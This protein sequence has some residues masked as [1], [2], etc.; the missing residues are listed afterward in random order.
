MMPQNL[1][2]A[3][4]QIAVTQRCNLRCP[5]C[6]SDAY[7][8]PIVPHVAMA[9]ID[10]SLKTILARYN[11]VLVETGTDTSIELTGGEPTCRADICDIV[12]IGRIKGFSRISLATNGLRLAEF[13]R[14]AQRLV[15]AGLD[16]IYLQFDGTDDLIDVTL[17]G[18]ALLALRQATI[19]A[20]TEA[21]L[22]VVLATTVVGGVNDH[23]LVEIVSFAAEHAPTVRGVR[24][25]PLVPLGRCEL[26]SD[27]CGGIS[28]P[29]LLDLLYKQSDG[30]L[31]SLDFTIVEGEAGTQALLWSLGDLD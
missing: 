23:A 20:C 24:F 8:L 21:C 14:L 27:K 9:S 28:I 7:R 1:H 6:S 4:A 25:Q 10:L 18:Q 3:S 22:P 17:H 31:Q 15:T 12:A 19:K 5:L 16:S 11:E 26:P 2:T 13:P 30:V 29:T